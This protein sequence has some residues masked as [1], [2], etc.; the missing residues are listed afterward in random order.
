MG[1]YKLNAS[2]LQSFRNPGNGSRT[3]YEVNKMKKTICALIAGLMCV[4]AFAGCNKGD[5]KDDKITVITRESGSGTRGAF[6]ELFGIEEKNDAGEKEDKTIKTAEESNSTAVMITS[7]EGN[8]NA[9]GY[10]SLGALDEE[11][12]QA[13]SIDGTEASVENIKNGTYKVARPFMIA[14]KGDVSEAAQDFINY[15]MSD[16]G[17][18]IVEEKGYI[19]NGSTG[20]FAGTNPSG[21]LKIAGSSSVSPLMEKLI[22]GYNKLNASLKIELQQNDST[23]GINAVLDGTCDIGMASRELKSTETEK[24]ATPTEIAIDGIAVI[25]NKEC[26]VTTMTSA[27]VKD[28]YTGKITTWSELSK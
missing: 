16:E 1:A 9:I 28:I 12:V 11:K 26:G 14:T 2:I 4:S 3:N 15:I 20:P 5:N 25:V 7:V 13:L 27:Q 17:Q 8:R 22:E 19:S 6:I 10:I 18:T 24:G 21:T 23:S